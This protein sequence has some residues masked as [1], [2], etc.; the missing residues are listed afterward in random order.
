M[1]THY[2]LRPECRRILSLPGVERC[3]DRRDV[4]EGLLD[5]DL[6]RTLFHRLHTSDREALAAETIDGWP[7]CECT[8]CGCS[9]PATCTDDQGVPTC[10]ACR[11]YTTDDDGNVLCSQCDGVETV[12]ESCGAG[13]QTRTYLRQTP[14]PAPESDPAGEWACYWWTVGSD[15][16]VV[17]RHTSA[18]LAAQAVAAKDWPRPGDRTDY[19]CGYEVRQLVDG[20]WTVADND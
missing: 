2:P 9:E 16:H 20:E 10:E 3:C 7:E 15:A 5:G 18:E 13:N 12:V 8:G 14:P 19:L 6:G 4:L 17:S 11:D 1:S